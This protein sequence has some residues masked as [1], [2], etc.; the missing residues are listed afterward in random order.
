M[1]N[2]KPRVNIVAV[3]DGFRAMIWNEETGETEVILD[4][5]VDDYDPFD[6]K[7]IRRQAAIWI[8]N[9]RKAKRGYKS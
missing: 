8:R 2:F 3:S 7:Q 5:Y 4:P 6:Q 1:M 9:W